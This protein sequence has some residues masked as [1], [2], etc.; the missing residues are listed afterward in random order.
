LPEILIDK[1]KLKIPEF[2]HD[3]LL[4]MLQNR[5][6]SSG[7]TGIFP[8]Q[9]KDVADII[10][11]S[12]KNPARLLQLARERA[13]EL[14]LKVRNI[15]QAP[16]QA[17]EASGKFFSIKVQKAGVVE[18]RSPIAITEIVQESQ[19]EPSKEELLPDADNDDADML[20][21][22]V[23]QVPQAPRVQQKEITS[24]EKVEQVKVAK[25]KSKAEPKTKHDKV[26]EKLAQEFAKKKKRA[27]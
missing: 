9:D 19:D 2:G 6:E 23:T 5:I 10:K 24:L 18:E 27:R 1:L 15:P 16:S 25:H 21:K 8:F 13:I 12:G 17:K 20:E 7:G 11:R 26:V 14:S 4:E 22:V 3:Q